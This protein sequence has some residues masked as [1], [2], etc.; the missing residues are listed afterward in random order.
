MMR[1]SRNGLSKE[2]EAF[3]SLAALCQK[4]MIEQEVTEE[5]VKDVEL[6]E[7]FHA[8]TR[9]LLEEY[10]KKVKRRRVYKRM[11]KS[12]AVFLLV[13]LLPATVVLS[14]DAFRRPF[15]N[16]LFEQHE[17]YVVITENDPEPTGGVYNEPVSPDSWFMPSY[18]PAGYALA[19]EQTQE[20]KQG[21]TLFF[22]DSQGKEIVFM[23]NFDMEA[24]F[25]DN[26]DA[27]ISE[28]LINDKPAY[29]REKQGSS[30]LLWYEGK[31]SFALSSYMDGEELVRMAQSVARVER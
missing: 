10:D 12:A 23:Q 8:R 31:Y 20:G 6:S 4:Q 19:P 28:V 29:L 25:I 13:I 11:M 7:S 26:E 1:K 5:D 9:H 22:V 3:L 27:Q 17:E 16:M 15:F 21:I 30:I 2:E 14:V 18:I 24:T